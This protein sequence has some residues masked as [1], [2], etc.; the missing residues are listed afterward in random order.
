MEAPT[1]PDVLYRGLSSSGDSPPRPNGGKLL[2]PAVFLWLGEKQLAE[3]GRFRLTLP[4]CWRTL[5]THS[6]LP[7]QLGVVKDVRLSEG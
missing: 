3:K 1:P 4:G 7:P 6:I 2:F 5:G